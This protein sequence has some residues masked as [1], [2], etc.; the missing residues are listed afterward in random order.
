M[1]RATPRPGDR[2]GSRSDGEGSPGAPK[3]PSNSLCHMVTTR[4]CVVSALGDDLGNNFLLM[5][6]QIKPWP[7]STEV[8][9]FIEAAL[10]IA[11]RK[12]DPARI[13]EIKITG[14][15]QIRTWV[16]PIEVRRKPPNAAAAANSVQFAVA[17]ALCHGEVTLADFTTD[18]I[19]DAGALALAQ[20]V[21]HSFDDRVRGG[22]IEVVTLDGQRAQAHV[23]VPLG[24]PSRPVPPERIVAKF[25]DCCRYA[26]H[27]LSASRVQHLVDMVENLENVADVAA[28]ITTANGAS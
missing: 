2:V 9:P 22:R 18:G 23:E 26:A 28:L 3:Y 27:T 15:N 10:E 13:D 1:L 12:I 21:S 4:Y 14:P 7:T 16:E 5:G 25:R 20:R 17:K 6:T 19:V 24:H 11:A 8:H